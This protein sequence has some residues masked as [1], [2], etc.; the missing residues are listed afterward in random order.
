[1]EKRLFLYLDILGFTELLKDP[2][3]VEELYQ[4]VDRLNVF[5]HDTFRCIVFSDTLLI[6]ETTCI[7]SNT[8]DL[9]VSIMWLCEF[10][11]DLLYRLISTDRHFR[12]ILTLGEFKCSN[13]EN[14]Q[15]YY[16]NALVET[17]NYEKR[18]H[19]T[20]LFIHKSL[21]RYSDIFK[22]TAYDSEYDYVYLTQDLNSI[23]DSY[24]GDSDSL[25]YLVASQGLEGLYVY[26]LI[27]LRNI[28][29]NMRDTSLPGSTRSKYVNTWHLLQVRY[30][31]IMDVLV[32]NN[33]NL[34]E[35]IN[36]DWDP[37]LSR[38]NNKQGFHG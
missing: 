16:G 4:I 17:Y 31:E 7:G 19:S 9:S 28:Y 35:L 11:Q 15:Y 37:W 26:D 24:D 38:V 12:A 33:F 10:A 18:I 2:N 22:T 14:I 3:D 23:S 1:M 5:S 36:I 32:S 34:S 27:Y 20:G 30:K 8:A 25:A 21:T 13:L 6:Y 29:K